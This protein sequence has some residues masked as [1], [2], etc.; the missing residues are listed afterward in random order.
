MAITNSADALQRLKVLIDSSTPI[1]AM[2]TVEE[3]RAVRMVR[4]ACTALNLAA[5]EWSVASGLIRCGSTVG[6]VVTGHEF[7]AVVLGFFTSS[8]HSPRS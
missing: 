2:E 4:A 8:P 1:V 3:V 5:F 6:D 7:A